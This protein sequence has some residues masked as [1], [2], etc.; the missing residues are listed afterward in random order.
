MDASQ[1][2]EL[3]NLE[4]ARENGKAQHGQTRGASSRVRKS[5]GKSVP[6]E[7]KFSQGGQKQLW[8]SL[9][10]ASEN[11]MQQSFVNSKKSSKKK[12]ILSSNKRSAK[13]IKE[14][15]KKELGER[16]AAGDSLVGERC[17]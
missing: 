10:F 15:M 9:K 7:R 4:D 2:L 5:V 6:K 11:R 17:R 8:D 1:L 12:T 3:K 14:V 13:P 16:M